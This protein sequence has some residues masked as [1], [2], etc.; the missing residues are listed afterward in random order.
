MF[1]LGKPGLGKSTVIRRMVLGLA[2]H[3]VDAAGA[4]RPEARLQG[5]DRG[6]RRPGHPARPR[7][8]LPE[9]PRP[10]R[11]AARPRSGSPARPAQ[12]IQADAHGRRQTMVS[13]LITIM[14]SAPPTDH[15][16]TILDQALRVLDE[17]F[18]GMPV[19]AR[20]APG[21]PGGAGPGP[22]GRPGPRRP[23]PLPADHRGL[24]AS[25]IGLIGGGRLGEIFSEQ[26]D[27]P[28]R[29][30]VRSSSTSP[31]STTP[32]RTCRPPCCWRAGRTGSARSTSRTPSPTPAWNRG[33]TTSSSS[34]SCGGRCAPAA[35]W[36]TGSTP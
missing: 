19:L 10:G 11:G 22:R 25:L 6:A 2:G 34:T 21:H 35:A 20:P 14:R 16:E 29:G 15:E 31:A 3:G 13:A 33:G 36:S 7:P 30:T 27:N 28:M 24:E 18:D 23:G 5:P 32:R 9:H 1:V 26:T 12:A 17:R 4:G 8:R